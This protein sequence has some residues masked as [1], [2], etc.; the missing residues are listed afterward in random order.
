M[1]E[2]I[3]EMMELEKEMTGGANQIVAFGDNK[4]SSKTDVFIET[5]ID[6]P[7]M[8]FN[9]EN[10]SIKKLNDNVDKEFT[11]CDILVKRYEKYYDEPIINEETGEIKEKE[12]KLITILI[13]SDGTPYVTASKTFCFAIR[14]LANFYT[15]EQ[16]KSGVKMKIIKTAVKNSANQALSFE[17]L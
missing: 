2:E 3:N 9:L 11:I 5:T 6:D 8:L 12:I 4:M 15:T 13:D 1:N 7:K 10:I 16:I 14:K 17:L